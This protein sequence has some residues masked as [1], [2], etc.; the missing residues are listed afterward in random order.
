VESYV[1]AMSKKIIF[2]VLSSLAV[3]IGG[4][5][6]SC[7]ANTSTSTS[8]IVQVPDGCFLLSP[9]AQ[10]DLGG[11]VV[12]IQPGKNPFTLDCGGRQVGVT[13]RIAKDQHSVA[14]TDEELRP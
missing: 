1:Q 5:F 11:P 3:S 4:F 12:Q 2:A 7:G 8:V 14:F 9:K 10:I 6:A 13:K